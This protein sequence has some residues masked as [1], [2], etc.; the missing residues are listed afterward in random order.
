M[1]FTSIE[2]VL[3]LVVTFLGYQLLSF[4][5]LNRVSLLFLALASLFFVGWWNWFLLP[6]LLGSMLWN[7][8]FGALVRSGSQADTSPEK[9]SKSALLTIGI[10]G[11]LFLL[12]YFKYSNWLSSVFMLETSGQVVLPIGISFYTFTQVAYL[13]DSYKSK[14]EDYDALRYL[15]FVSFFPQLIAGP[16]V[17]HREMM[18][19][20]EKT[21]P[22]LIWSK[23]MEIG[24]T[25]FSIGLAKKILIADSLAERVDFGYSNVQQLDVWGAWVTSLAYSMQLYFD[26]SGYT[27][28]ALGLGLIFGIRLPRNFNSPYKAV[29]IQDFWRRWHMTLSRFLRDYI[30]IPLGGNKRGIRVEYF[31][32]IAT[33]LLGGL[34]H[35]AG[36]TFIFWGLVHGIALV[37]ER[38]IGIHTMNGFRRLRIA[39]T[40]LFVNFA[41]ILFRA[42][43]LSTAWE[44][45]SRH[46]A[47]G[48][49]GANSEINR[50][51]AE[52]ISAFPDNPL[53]E[54][55]G[56]GFAANFFPAL[57]VV[58]SLV[59]VFATPNSNE[60]SEKRLTTIGLI[61]IFT[62][63]LFALFWGWSSGNEIFLYF[64]F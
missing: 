9:S 29:S 22:K 32:L 49:Q 57:L 39:V 19:Q 24:A 8:F 43:D 64:N 33:F 56:E 11:N 59:L 42:P 52:G 12:G 55:L 5:K 31:A 30:Y 10:L 51:L 16:I 41:W 28:M 15:L 37:L 40:F 20:F 13:V 17:H 44:L 48:N 1:L 38:T 46:F 21:T 14:V 18:P 53:V 60:L 47:S 2:F 27:D 61:S 62:V 36:F 6:V 4:L 50:Y 35:G 23:N 26:F 25:L 45:F 54:L 34:W 7:L 63:G 3:F 58:V